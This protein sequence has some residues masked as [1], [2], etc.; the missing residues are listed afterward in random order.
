MSDGLIKGVDFTCLAT[1]DHDAACK[2]YEDVLGLERSKSWGSMPA[3]EF[4]TG[5]LTIAV[6]DWTAFGREN[7]PNPN[8]IV[9]HVEEVNNAKPELESRGVEFESEVIDSG[10]CRQ[11]YFSDPDGNTLGI[12][13]FYGDRPS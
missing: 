9:L 5:S 13:S 6:I 3:T 8:P 4:E 12:H 11:A 7:H 10:F 1:A 2:F